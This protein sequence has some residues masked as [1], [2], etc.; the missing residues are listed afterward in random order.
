MHTAFNHT[1]TQIHLP[2]NRTKIQSMIRFHLFIYFFVHL[3]AP[4]HRLIKVTVTSIF[5]IKCISHLNQSTSI[6]H[7]RINHL[8]W[9]QLEEFRE[10][11]MPFRSIQQFEL[12]HFDF[13]NQIASVSAS[14]QLIC[15]MRQKKS[16]F[17]LHSR[18]RYSLRDYSLDSTDAD[19]RCTKMPYSIRE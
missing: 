10:C 19:I 4:V 18:S 7:F 13:I 1:H 11:S 12:I 6:W 17:F 3:C 2:L 14:Q 9:T 15:S 16:F 8:I 5:H